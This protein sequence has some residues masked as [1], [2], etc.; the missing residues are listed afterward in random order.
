MPVCR[1]PIYWAVAFRAPYILLAAAPPRG[2]PRVEYPLLVSDRRSYLLLVAVLFVWAG[3]FPLGKLALS[4]V[5]PL[6]LVGGRTLMAAPLLLG[7]AR[8]SAP[9]DRPLVRRDYVAFSV[10]GL[11]GLVLNTTTWY[12]GL[13]WTTALNAGILGAASPIFVALGAAVLLGERLRPRTWAG[14]ALTVTAVVVTVAKGSL[15]VMLELAF[16]R[17][18]LIILLSQTAWV[19]YSLY[20][21]AAASTLRPVWVMAGANAVGAM[22]LVPLSWLIEGPWPS[23]VTAPVGWGVMLYGAL[24]ITI[25]HLW[26]YQVIRRLGPSRTAAFMNLMPFA[27]IAMS[28]AL[29]GEAVH[30]YHVAGAVLVIAGVVLTTAR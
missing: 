26:Y 14:I 5:G 30:A 1:R 10:L 19:A 8:L 16:N 29:V 28:W 20:S 21:R 25:A 6:F 27:V 2:P 24:P 15:A 18:D 23:P 11:T 12:W 3:N 9:L 13:K 17:G 4:E 7:L 22:V